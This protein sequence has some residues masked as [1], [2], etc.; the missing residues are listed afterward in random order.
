MVIKHGH[1]DTRHTPRCALAD[2][3]A[4][5]TQSHKEDALGPWLLLK[6]KSTLH[7]RLGS[8]KAGTPQPPLLARG[9]HYSC[10]PAPEQKLKFISGETW[11]GRG[12]PGGLGGRALC[13]MGGAQGTVGGAPVPPAM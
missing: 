4:L 12:S 1:S 11:A 10:L 2:T 3:L 5:H 7:P 8:P 9:T 13:G 6:F